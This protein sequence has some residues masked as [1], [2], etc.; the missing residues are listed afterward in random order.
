ML[1]DFPPL[2]MLYA[3]LGC[4]ALSPPLPLGRDHQV[5]MQQR[6][7]LWVLAAGG[8]I[9]SEGASSGPRRIVGAK[10]RCVSE[11]QPTSLRSS[12]V[13]EMSLAEQRGVA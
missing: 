4:I 11:E 6:Q 8:G 2:E 12:D 3:N 13:G 1:N 9:P 10:K 5:I 7:L